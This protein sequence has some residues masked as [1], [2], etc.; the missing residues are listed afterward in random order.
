MRA[1][2]VGKRNGR[3]G[4]E[5]RGP[6][7]EELAA[8]ATDSTV[9][10]KLDGAEHEVSCSKERSLLQSA[11]AQGVK[12]PFSCEDGYCG[13]CMAKLVKGSVTMRCHDALTDAE[14]E[15]GWILTCQARPTASYCQV[16]YD[17]AVDFDDD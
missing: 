1:G 5:G 6:R 4:F 13:C 10:V 11:L 8:Q 16:D 15:R 9:L 7:D 2:D 17:A 14:V 12:P 3:G